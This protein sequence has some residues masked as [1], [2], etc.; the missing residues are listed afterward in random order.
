LAGW[1]PPEPA[2]ASPAKKNRNLTWIDLHASE[3]RNPQALA[4]G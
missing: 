3:K 1:S 2:S 4:D